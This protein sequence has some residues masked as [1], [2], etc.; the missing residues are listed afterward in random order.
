[1]TYRIVNECEY[2]NDTSP[3]SPVTYADVYLTA[4][5]GKFT[6]E[7]LKVC[8]PLEAYNYAEVS[9]KIFAAVTV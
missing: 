5:P 4:T 2:V 9:Y 6:R 7:L 1:M 3:W 8:K